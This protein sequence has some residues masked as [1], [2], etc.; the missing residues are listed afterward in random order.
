[1][2]RPESDVCGQ[3]LHGRSV[4]SDPRTELIPR[5]PSVNRIELDRYL[6]DNAARLATEQDGKARAERLSGTQMVLDVSRLV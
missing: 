6:I 2:L 5:G 1:M 4:L 3:Q